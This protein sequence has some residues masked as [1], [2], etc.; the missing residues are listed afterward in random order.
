MIKSAYD[1]IILILVLLA[2]LV[3]AG[4]LY[5]NVGAGKEDMAS[6]GNEI[7]S[8]TKANPNAK[9][10]DVSKYEDAIVTISNPYQMDLKNSSWLLWCLKVQKTK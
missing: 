9:M 10:V 6:V 4:Y 8:Y 1:K 5:L 7:V 2:L 3:T